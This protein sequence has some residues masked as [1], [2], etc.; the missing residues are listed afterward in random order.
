M[1][2]SEIEGCADNF[3]KLGCLLTLLITIPIL[4]LLFLL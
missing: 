3:A 2:K 4:I 1:E